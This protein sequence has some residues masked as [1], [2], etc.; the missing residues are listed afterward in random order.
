MQLLNANSILTTTTP[1]VYWMPVSWTPHTRALL[2]GKGNGREKRAAE[3]SSGG[4]DEDSD[5]HRSDR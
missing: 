1:S 2:G 4:E 5:V 3:E